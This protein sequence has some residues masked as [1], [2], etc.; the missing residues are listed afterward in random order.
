MPINFSALTRPSHRSV[1][2]MKVTRGDFFIYSDNE[3]GSYSPSH[4]IYIE[5]EMLT[6]AETTERGIHSLNFIHDGVAVIAPSPHGDTYLGVGHT[7][8][9]ARGIAL[10][11]AVR[12]DHWALGLPF[13]PS[14][15]REEVWVVDS[16]ECV[17]TRFVH[18]E[19]Q[20]DLEEYKGIDEV[21]CVE[22]APSQFTWSHDFVEAINK[23][24]SHLPQS[25]QVH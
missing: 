22:Y 4:H 7:E 19:S 24:I 18:I 3:P 23:F 1:E 14:L 15:N 11:Q 16:D 10:V 6:H 2:T 21:W 17:P 5:D 9:Q 25:W 13:T 12:Y 20:E 8:E